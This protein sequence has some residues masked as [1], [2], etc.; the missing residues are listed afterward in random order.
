MTQND[1]GWFAI[2]LEAK[3]C[4]FGRHL[5]LLAGHGLAW[6]ALVLGV[7]KSFGVQVP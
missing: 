4:R 1:V 6:L 5:L 3:G 2:L 7:L